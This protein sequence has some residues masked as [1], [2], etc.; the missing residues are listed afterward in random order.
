M[1]GQAIAMAVA[2]ERA[3]DDPAAR[4][5][6]LFETH[7]QRLYRLARRLS[8]SSEDARDL[9][10]ETFLRAARSPHSV[11]EG[12]PHEEAWLVRVLVNICRDRWRQIA[13]RRYHNPSLGASTSTAHPESAL[14][15][16]RLIQQALEQLPPRRRAV[17]VLYELEGKPIPAIARLL[18]V[19]AVTV[20]WH[21]SIGRR[22]MVK[23]LE[24]TVTT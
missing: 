18:G 1:T 14:I 20:R 24:G 6:A 15:A 19:S 2:A 7:H 23:V 11:P 16:R 12:T 5:G 4:V 9:V 21:L 3:Q 8:G 17:L 13:V 22:E 10:Q